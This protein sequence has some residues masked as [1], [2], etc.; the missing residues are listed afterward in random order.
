VDYLLVRQ[1][2]LLVWDWYVPLSAVR[3]VTNGGVQLAVNRD[4]LVRN[5]WNVPPEKYL[6]RQGA[7]PGYAYTSPADIP[8]YGATEPESSTS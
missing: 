5:H 2:S 4:D 3:A 7:T 1:G 6:T 8:P